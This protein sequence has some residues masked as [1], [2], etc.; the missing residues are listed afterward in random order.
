MTAVTQT[1]AFAKLDEGTVKDFITKVKKYLKYITLNFFSG[2]TKWSLQV[3]MMARVAAEFKVEIA[4]RKE[5]EPLILEP[6]SGLPRNIDVPHQGPSEPT[7]SFAPTPPTAHRLRPKLCCDGL[8]RI[9]R[10]SDQTFRII[11]GLTPPC[12]PFSFVYYGCDE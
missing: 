3:M 5:E 11:P 6:S 2:C 8:R 10:R 4:Q 7:T 9:V 12:F 1:E